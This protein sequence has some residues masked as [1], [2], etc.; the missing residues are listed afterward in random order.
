LSLPIVV[1]VVTMTLGMI[2]YDLMPTRSA[3]RGA[4]ENPG[5]T[6]RADG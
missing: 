6:S 1:F 4:V 2:G 3:S 5:L